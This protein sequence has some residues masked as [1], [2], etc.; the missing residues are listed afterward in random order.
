MLWMKTGYLGKLEKLQSQDQV[1][2]EVVVLVVEGAGQVNVLCYNE[3]RRVLS[4][5]RFR[6]FK[7]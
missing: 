6:V 5:D 7:T 2:K 1:L 3:R 4:C